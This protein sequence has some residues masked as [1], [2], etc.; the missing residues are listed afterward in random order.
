LPALCE[1]EKRGGRERGDNAEGNYVLRR[2]GGREGGGEVLAKG[3]KRGRK[4]QTSW[5]KGKRWFT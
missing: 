2:F 4:A 1:R 3:E 5:W